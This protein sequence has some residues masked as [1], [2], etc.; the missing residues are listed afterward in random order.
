MKI[1]ILSVFLSAVAA[2]SSCAGPME[3]AP[4][5]AT[6]DPDAVAAQKLMKASV[7]IEQEIDIELT[8]DML[9]DKTLAVPIKET[10]G[11]TG[12]GVVVANDRYRDSKGSSL[13]MTAGHVCDTPESMIMI[14]FNKEGELYGG[15][16]KVVAHRFKTIA[17]DGRVLKTEVVSYTFSEDPL[18][19]E[20]DICAIST[21]GMAGETVEL[22]DQLPPEGAIV[23]NV[24][25]PMGYQVR[26]SAHISDGRY[27]GLT[28][29]VPHGAI[30]SN[31]AVGGLSGSGLYYRGKLFAILVAG[32]RRFEHL[33][34]GTELADVRREMLRA[35]AKWLNQ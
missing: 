33:T 20:P 25:F 1:A 13:I 10:R 3:N 27:S 11:W 5:R 23:Q 19:P 35:R 26:W 2:C 18:D 15:I 30:V 14:G 32:A 16:A 12:S 34:F 24:G 31:P 17:L 28:D 9:G 6:S 4:W 22:A 8:E 29:K 21:V 7:R